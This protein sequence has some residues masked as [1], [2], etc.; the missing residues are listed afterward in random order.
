MSPSQ[1]K[2]K[3]GGSFDNNNYSS[4]QIMQQTTFPSGRAFP[5][6]EV[7]SACETPDLDEHYPATLETRNVS[8]YNNF[9]EAVTANTVIVRAHIKT[10]SEN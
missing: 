2:G 5:I 6:P 4:I 7:Y 8:N 10:S 9:D 3:I 1:S